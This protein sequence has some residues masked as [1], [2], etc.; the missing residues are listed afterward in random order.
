MA[1]LNLEQ[2]GQLRNSA[3]FNQRLAVAVAKTANYWIEYNATDN[4][5]VQK[6]K[7]FAH[8]I[9]QNGTIPSGYALD[10]VARYNEATPVLE[11]GNSPF[12][13]ATNQLAD[14]QLTDS[15]TSAYTFDYQAGVVAGDE[16]QSA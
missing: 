8:T 7:T 2:R 6:R 5:A 3:R 4:L 10:F 14:S 11:D 9:L 15:S 16:N 12:D 13:A 1:Q